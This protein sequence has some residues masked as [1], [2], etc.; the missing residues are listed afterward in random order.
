MDH[1]SSVESSST[2]QSTVV[3]DTAEE[4][5]SNTVF[6][7]SYINHISMLA[8]PLR[9]LYSINISRVG[10]IS[11]HSK[12]FAILRAWPSPCRKTACLNKC[13]PARSIHEYHV[14]TATRLPDESFKKYL[15]NLNRRYAPPPV[16]NMPEQRS[17]DPL[18]WIDCEVREYHTWPLQRF[19]L[20]PYQMT[21]RDC[22]TD[23]IL[24]VACFVTDAQLNL[25]DEQGF[26]EVIHHEQD[27]IDRMGEWCTRQHGSSGLITATKYSTNTH[28][29]VAKDLL[30]Y[31]QRYIK[32]P[33][34]ALLAGNSV[35][36]DR[37]FLRKPPYNQVTDYL[38]YRIYDVSV[39]KEFVRRFGSEDVLK[40]SP[41]KKGLHDARADILESIEEARYQVK[42]IFRR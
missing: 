28:Q 35:H 2:L 34:R 30:E 4:E 1:E 40:N 16:F 33:G 32:I 5:F 15:D 18:V 6:A 8:P 24:S 41:E 20:T 10:A 37:A 25:L 23:T 9:S 22:D 13:R 19:R 36:A 7:Q 17:Q 38:H 14:S 39:I 26:Y 29:Q 3:V 31:I 42:A 11:V 27:A 21:G 12:D